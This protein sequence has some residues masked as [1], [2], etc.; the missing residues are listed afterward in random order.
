MYPA[1][2]LTPATVIVALPIFTTR[3]ACM[4]AS[5]TYTFPAL[6]TATDVGCPNVAEV[7]GPLSPYGDYATNVAMR[8]AATQRR[9][10]RELAAEIA[11]AAGA[12]EGVE[13]A[14]VA[15]PGS[16]HCAAVHACC[17][18]PATVVMSPLV[19]L[20]WRITKLPVSAM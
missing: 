2:M 16:P 18:V 11:A 4:D 7:A 15:G 17:G 1:G 3:I 10:P 5:A 13:R 6:S 14:E 12:L 8:L 9:P 20:Y 19:G